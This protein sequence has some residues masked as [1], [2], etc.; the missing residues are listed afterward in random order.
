MSQD[1]NESFE[2]LERRARAA[3]DASVDGLD[4]HTRS[5]LGQARQRAMSI[6]VGRRHPARRWLGWI[7]AGALAASVLAGALLLRGPTVDESAHQVSAQGEAGAQESLEAFAASED[8]ELA[9]EADPDFYALV[10]LAALSDA[11]M[12]QT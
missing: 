3:F 2:Q 9:A 1:R 11:G 7:S 6:A 5:R 12:G 10:D 4:A 8:L